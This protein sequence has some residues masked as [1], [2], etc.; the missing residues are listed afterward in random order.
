MNAAIQAL[1]TIYSTVLVKE[2]H[3]VQLQQFKSVVEQIKYDLNR[4]NRVQFYVKLLKDGRMK[5]WRQAYK[6]AEDD[7]NENNM[8]FSMYP[9]H[10]RD[11]E[12]SVI[13]ESM[14]IYEKEEKEK[15][16]AEQKLK[17]EEARKKRQEEE[18]LEEAK[19]RLAERDRELTILALMTRLTEEQGQQESR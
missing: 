7:W 6:E 16:L 2:C 1:E 14:A 17:E 10:M 11:H 8:A 4:K 15:K 9:W 3:P 13:G 5:A 18:L 19:R 12:W